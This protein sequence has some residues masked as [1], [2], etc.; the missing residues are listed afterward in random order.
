VHHIGTFAK[1]EDQQCAFT[2]DF[3]RQAA[4]YSPDRLD[5]LVW[6][7]TELMVEN[8]NDSII[9][10]YRR[11]NVARIEAK[12]KAEAPPDPDGF[13]ALRCPPGATTAYGMMGDRYTAD[14]EGLIRVKPDDV[15]A[16]RNAGFAE[17]IREN[18]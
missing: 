17:H 8:P 14:A 4:G 16:L 15:K 18:G 7:I 6:A 1:L 11:E 13:V 2:P 10:F 3:D 5:A 12:A 9:E